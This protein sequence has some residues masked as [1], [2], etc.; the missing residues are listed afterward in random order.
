MKG[1]RTAPSM[2]LA[3]VLAVACAVT[4]AVLAW[5]SSRIVD[6]TLHHR[7]VGV[8]VAAAVL[9]VV[10]LALPLAV[11]V[12]NRGRLDRRAGRLRVVAYLALVVSVTAGLSALNV[13]QQGVG[14]SVYC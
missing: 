1:L 7:R 8:F 14:C 5:D 4:S 2:G 12:L 3:L 10:A 9:E 6:P 13:Y 11:L